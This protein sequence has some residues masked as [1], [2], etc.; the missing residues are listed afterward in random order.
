M[1][2]SIK[3]VDNWTLNHHSIETGY[4]PQRLNIMKIHIR[5][6][7]DFELHKGWKIGLIMS[8][9]C[10]F[11]SCTF[12]DEEMLCSFVRHCLNVR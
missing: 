11:H 1:I 7:L 10:H 4:S 8:R 2:G 6:I 12:S 3:A 5:S 9:S